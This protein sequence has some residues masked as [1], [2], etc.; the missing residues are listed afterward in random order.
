MVSGLLF[1]RKECQLFL[2]H[3]FDKFLCPVYLIIDELE[4]ILAV[5]SSFQR[6]EFEAWK[7]MLDEVIVQFE[8]NAAKVP[9]FSV[10]NVYFSQV[11]LSN[12]ALQTNLMIINE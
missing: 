12:L 11:I 9:L 3:I 2:F 10:S 8:M 5:V 1:V 7:N 4:A 6:M